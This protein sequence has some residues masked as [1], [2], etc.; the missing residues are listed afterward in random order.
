[1]GQSEH[2]ISEMIQKDL[3]NLESVYDGYIADR[4][5]RRIEKNLELFS[6]YG[7]EKKIPQKIVALILNLENSHPMGCTFEPDYKKQKFNLIKRLLGIK[8]L[9]K[10]SL[11]KINQ[12]LLL[13]GWESIKS[14]LFDPLPYLTLSDSR[15]LNLLEQ[16]TLKENLTFYHGDLPECAD[17]LNSTTFSD[18]LNCTCRIL[19]QKI[20]TDN[21]YYSYMA[22]R[23]ADYAAYTNNEKRANVCLCSFIELLT[24]VDNKK[25]R[26]LL[27][28]QI[29]KI[30]NNPHIN[31]DL[32]ASPI[33]GM[34]KKGHQKTVKR[35]HPGMTPSNRLN[36]GNKIY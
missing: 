36:G 18:L 22:Q 27:S 25:K 2:E 14:G 5:F 30:K 26:A 6:S 19:S 4:H 17:R 20:I 24:R 9:K 3:K 15:D 11:R 28:E 29:E 13:K 1:M 35:R 12:W 31:K 8:K 23:L 16:M 32:F 21:G 7:S 33:L 10:S 34:P